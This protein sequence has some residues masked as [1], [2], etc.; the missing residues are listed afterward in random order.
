[1][2]IKRKIIFSVLLSLVFLQPF[3]SMRNFSVSTDELTHLPSGYSYWKTGEIKLNPQHPPLV[4]LLAS[5]PLLFMNIDFDR[6]DSDLAGVKPNEWKFGSKLLFSNDVNTMIFWGRMMM[7]LLSLILAIYIF[8]WTSEMF[9]V[10]AG[11]FS[12]FLYTFVPN[13]IAHAPLITTDVGVTA[14]MTVALYYLWKLLKT[15]SK[16]YIVL[17]GI[18]L[19]LALG[20]KFSAVFLIPIFV[21]LIFVHLFSQK[22]S[23]RGGSAKFIQFLK[24]TIP[25]FVIAFFVIYALY[26]FP[27]DIGFYKKGLDS[28]YADKNL[29]YQ[30]YLNGNFK[31]GGWWYYFLEAFLIKNPISLLVFFAL[32]ILFYK[33]F[34]AGLSAQT[35]KLDNTFLFLPLGVYFFATSVFAYDLGVRYLM[36][37]YP[38]LIISAGRI[39]PILSRFSFS[40]KNLGGAGAIILAGLSGWYVI[41]SVMVY[42]NYL[43]Y[44]GE[45]VGGSDN[46]YKYLDDSNIDWGQDL[47]RLKRFI[48]NNPDAF[49]VYSHIPGN[50]ALQYYGIDPKKN[51][52]YAKQNWWA[53]PK[54]TY[55]IGSHFL[56]RAQEN[57]I[58]NWLN[59]YKPVE[60]IGQSFFI[61][62]F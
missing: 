52:F 2:D 38:F 15:K 10:D 26:L 29:S 19:G 34:R 1:M 3:L 11:L 47:K 28:V 5:F 53:N 20:A 23:A 60:K 62:K 30:F 27:H 4:K 6:N 13:I 14:F 42:P 17:S 12:L 55:V 37:I 44:F 50:P 25:I 36:P 22:I 16:K 51:L 40:K 35:G 58:M 24:I 54:G 7:I 45:L 49:V 31:A 46:G 32:G 9:S 41:S 33:K 56:I 59:L 8:K 48:D 18:A 57:K 43:S 39:W 21:I 61:Y